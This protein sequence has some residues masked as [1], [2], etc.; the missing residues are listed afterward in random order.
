[1]AD[2]GFDA[3]G[4]DFAGYGESD[5]YLEM[6][7]PPDSNPPLGRAEVCSRQIAAAVRAILARQGVSRVSL[8]AHSWGTSP[9][10]L[11]A[12]R[13]P[14]KVDRLVPFGPITPSRTPVTTN[15]ETRG[16]YWHASKRSTNPVLKVRPRS[17]TLG[18]GG[19]EWRE[20]ESDG[21]WPDWCDSGRGAAS[22][23]TRLRGDMA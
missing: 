23:D 4:L 22:R 14:A 16:A 17:L 2:A 9:A 8:V 15:A 6:R 21:A 7:E 18:N 3:W 11:Y 12:T 1:M 19:V 10:G 20:T 5:R 13:E